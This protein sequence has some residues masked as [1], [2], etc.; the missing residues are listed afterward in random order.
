M[1]RACEPRSCYD[2]NI[3]ETF[4]TLTLIF[5]VFLSIEVTF[6]LTYCKITDYIDYKLI[7]QKNELR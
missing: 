5:Y 1:T 3:F 4:A 7:R 6:V 2:N